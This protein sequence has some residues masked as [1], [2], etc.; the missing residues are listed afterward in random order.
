MEEAGGLVVCRPA[1]YHTGRAGDSNRGL[2]CLTKKK[3]KDMNKNVQDFVIETI[4]SIASKIPGISIR[5]AYDIQTNFHIVEV[6][7]ESIRRGNEEYMEME[8]NLCNE[9][10]EK[11][12]EE[13]L[14]VSEP[15]R[16]NNMENLIFE[17]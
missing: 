9:F 3:K 7:P 4:Q 6:S 14:L 11:F 16:I 1:G 13:D 8:Y 5:Y 2:D 15:D 12:P 10:Y 17:I